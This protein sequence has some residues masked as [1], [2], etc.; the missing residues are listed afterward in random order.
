MTREQLEHIIRAAGAVTDEKVILVLGSQS[1]L[2]HEGP[3]PER[4]L[5]SSEADVFPLKAPNKVDLINGS[6]GEITQFQST[7]GYYA[8]GLPPEAC[9]LPKGWDKRLH[10][11]KNENTANV[12][13]LCIDAKDLACSKLAAGR[14]KDLDFVEEMMKH[15]IVS[16]ADMDQLI[17]S[18]PRPEFESAAAR[19]LV[20]I[21]GRIR[22]ASLFPKPDRDRGDKSLEPEQ[23]K[24]KREELE[25]E[26]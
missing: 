2:G 23:P 17:P 20:I 3:I 15:G 18:L 21:Q 7:F 13:G 24:R 9:P 16:N 25:R 12:M 14:P 8:H 19:S 22:Q 11:I 26:L 5:G 6:I 1:I 10:L 4:L